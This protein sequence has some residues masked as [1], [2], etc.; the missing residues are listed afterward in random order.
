MTAIG[1]PG[2]TQ[3][4]INTASCLYVDGA[5]TLRV[6]YRARLSSYHT[7]TSHDPSARHQHRLVSDVHH[8]HRHSEVGLQCNRF[9][10][11]QCAAPA[12]G[13]HLLRADSIGSEIGE[14]G[15]PRLAPERR[16]CGTGAWIYSYCMPTLPLQTVSSGA[17]IDVSEIY[18]QNSNAPLAACIFQAGSTLT[19]S[20]VNIW[21][22]TR[23]ELQGDTIMP[24]TKATQLSID[25]GIAKMRTHAFTTLF[26]SRCTLV[27]GTFT[28]DRAQISSSAYF[29]STSVTIQGPSVT[30]ENSIYAQLVLSGGSSYLLNGPLKMY[31]GNITDDGTGTFTSFG[32]G[33]VSFEQ[34]TAGEAGIA[35]NNLTFGGSTV[36]TTKQ[37][38]T[39]L[40]LIANSPVVLKDT[41]LLSPGSTSLTINAP[42]GLSLQ[43]QAGVTLQGALTI[44]GPFSMQ[45]GGVVTL[46]VASASPSP[47]Q[48]QGSTVALAGTARLNFTTYVPSA[49]SN[50]TVATFTAAHTGTWSAAVASPYAAWPA[51]AYDSTAAYMIGV[52]PRTS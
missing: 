49:P 31:S 37:T 16:E 13:L 25:S 21:S 42:S 10:W 7:V 19:A 17:A 33:V 51:T 5:L 11:Q 15:A 39:T 44:N 46:N 50:F 27:G 26:C 34:T 2:G 6:R 1:S 18:C 3:W 28:F 36:I 4:V 32:P 35:V 40:N 29:N 47:L 8:D 14:H 12:V 24:A 45:A 52:I 22:N 41:T 48:L 23:F 9:K 43:N 38:L 30:G 20:S